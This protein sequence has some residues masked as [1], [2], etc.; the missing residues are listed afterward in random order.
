MKHDADKEQGWAAIDKIL[1]DL[2]D[3]L[4]VSV[5]NDELGQEVA[6]RKLDSQSPFRII[7][8]QQSAD[9]PQRDVMELFLMGSHSCVNFLFRMLRVFDVATQ[10]DEQ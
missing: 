9:G 5:G 3:G 8:R 7:Q 6:N 4:I 10:I 2:E 1:A